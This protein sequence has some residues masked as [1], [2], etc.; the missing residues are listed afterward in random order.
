MWGGVCATHVECIRLGQRVH[1]WGLWTPRADSVKAM[2]RGAS[3]L[4]EVATPL[5]GPLTAASASPPLIKPSVSLPEPVPR[6]EPF[7]KK[8]VV[9][10]LSHKK[11]YNTCEGPGSPKG[12]GGTGSGPSSGPQSRGSALMDN[13]N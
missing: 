5:L 8:E 12:C 2:G 1:E 11:A 4:L 9:E 10:I 3:G 7:R 6:P 13:R